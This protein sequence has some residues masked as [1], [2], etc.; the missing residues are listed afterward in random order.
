MPTGLVTRL[1]KLGAG[2]T[3]PFVTPGVTPEKH[4]AMETPHE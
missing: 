1:L 4:C 3:A 2:I